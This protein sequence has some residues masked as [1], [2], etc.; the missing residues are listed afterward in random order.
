MDKA[1]AKPGGLLF[2]DIS[3]H[4]GWVYGGR[5][6][7]A[8]PGP[9]WG[10][11]EIE[12]YGLGRRMYALDCALSDALDRYNPGRVGIEAPL[13]VVKNRS[14]HAAELLLCLAGQAEA[15]CVRWEKPFFK[16]QFDK[17]RNAVLGRRL[18]TSEEAE[19]GL[20]V[21]SA[22]VEPW[23]TRM[24]WHIPDED[25]RDAAV[26]WAFEMGIRYRGTK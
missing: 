7:I 16:S 9:I 12:Q 21:K 19:R 15:T 22:I 11:W 3:L 4:T 14:G 17:T 8:A 2:L 18:M 5:E 23:V 10:K 24:G 20:T 25:A 13:K 6:H 26:G 1:P